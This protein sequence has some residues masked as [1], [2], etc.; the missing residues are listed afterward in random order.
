[1]ILPLCCTPSRLELSNTVVGGG[2]GDGDGARGAHNAAAVAAATSAV[3]ADGFVYL[4]NQ[5]GDGPYGGP[6]GDGPDSGST[7]MARLATTPTM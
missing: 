6:G 2:G 4:Q 7:V 3:A 1:L 5:P